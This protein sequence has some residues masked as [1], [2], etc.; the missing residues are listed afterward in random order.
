MRTI[1]NQYWNFEF[2]NKVFFKNTKNAP[3]NSKTDFS[4]KTNTFSYNE[5]LNIGK[6]INNYA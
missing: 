2:F 3:D 4:H 5:N 6:V 1:R